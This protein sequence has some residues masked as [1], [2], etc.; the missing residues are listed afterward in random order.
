MVDPELRVIDLW[1]NVAGEWE[2]LGRV[3]DASPTVQVELAG[4]TVPLDLREILRG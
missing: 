1:Q 2:L 3:D 4:V